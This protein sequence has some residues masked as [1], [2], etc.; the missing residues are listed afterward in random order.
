[1]DVYNYTEFDWVVRLYD[2]AGNQVAFVQ[3]YTSGTSDTTP[4]LEPVA[5]QTIQLG[6]PVQ[7]QL[8]ATDADGVAPVYGALSLPGGASLN[9]VSG[10][11]A[12]TPQSPGTYV[13]SFTATDNTDGPLTVE[14]VAT[15][16]VVSA[17][18]IVVQ[19]QN[20]A[21]AV[22]TRGV[23]FSVVATNSLPLTY[24]WFFNGIKIPAGT[25]STLKVLTAAKSK[26]GVYQV[27]V[28]NTN[29]STQ[30]QEAVLDVYTKRTDG[31]SEQFSIKHL[32]S[33]MDLYHGRV[34]VYDDIGS[35][36]N[37]FLAQGQLPNSHSMVT[38]NTSW[39]DKTHSGATAIQCTFQAVGETNWGGFYMMN[40]LLV[41]N[42]A[43]PY[44]GDPVIPG[45]SIAV[46]NW[47]GVNLSGAATLSFWLRGETGKEE[48]EFFM[49]GVGRDPTSGAA[50]NKFYDSTRRWPA[51]G[52]I[53]KTTKVWTRHTISLA[54]LN[55]TNIMGGFGWVANAMHNPTGAVFYLDDIQYN[56]KPGAQET[57]L[58]QPH[59]IRSY[60]TLPLQPGT[61][62]ENSTGNFDYDLRDTA[63]TYDNAVA[64]LAFLANG[65]EDSLRRAQII[66]DAFLYATT[67]DR[68]YTNG[69]VRSAYASGDIAVPPGWLVNG[70]TGTVAIPGFFDV[71][72]NAFY[73]VNNE[74]IDTGDNAWT[75]IALLALYEK[76]HNSSYLAAATA[77]G[78]YIQTFRADS[79]SYQG[80][81]G[82]ISNAETPDATPRVY[83]STEHNLDIYAAFTQM[84]K[85][86]GDSSWNNGVAHAQQF[87]E[88][89]FD[90][91]NGCYLTGTISPN[92]R[93]DLP[94]ELPLD[95]QA[96]SVLS[97]T[98]A[99]VLHPLLLSNAVVNLGCSFDGFTGFD[100]N[101]DKDGVWFE[102]TAQMC[103]AYATAGQTEMANTLAHTLS[104]AQ[105]MPAPFG[106]GYGL[107]AASHDGVT[108]GFST[109]YGPNYYYRRMHV[110]ATSWRV[111]AER[112]FNPY[113]QTNINS[114]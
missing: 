63:F 81:L 27:L 40:G 74:D 100:F 31:E 91:T 85:A 2:Q 13:I 110:G 21:V 58:N 12:W 90:A 73:E 32:D 35:G 8:I 49:G 37:H 36:G 71:S 68:Y 96:W 46:T 78:D 75:M 33:E 26:A 83:A 28:S 105:Q 3:Q 111:F 94:D 48:I 79:G 24:Q 61:P 72:S 57:R 4:I 108:T 47:A 42:I 20:Q 10:L 52:T 106:D 18:T 65:S 76:T 25:L 34:P 41:S 109:V 67:H 102:G 104:D 66:G 103:V 56:L 86:T 113:Y 45:T 16:T 97:L 95:V 69:Q 39:S 93:N 70:K 15:F 11:F 54:G 77:I 22:G 9:S 84:Y 107:V 62:E 17:P 5:S 44:F 59:F 23:M 112:G 55:L 38:M 53:F 29:A 1:M 89:M 101:D 6:Q 92:M 19:P 88:A 80:F 43:V 7:I 87:I 64:I 98:N 14:Q 30:S 50:T 51:S 99:L 60:V 82:G 114:K